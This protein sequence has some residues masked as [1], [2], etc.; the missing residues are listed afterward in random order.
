MSFLFAGI[1]RTAELSLFL[2][3]V[4]PGIASAASGP[5]AG[6]VTSSLTGFP[7]A[8]VVVKVLET[9]DSTQTDGTG[10][11]VFANLVNGRYTMLIGKPTYQPVTKANVFFGSC[12]QGTAG[13][14]DCD[15]TN[16]VDISDLSVLIDN[17]FISFS[18]L[19]C[20]A[21]AN[22]DGQPGVDI[23]DLSSLIDFL[24]ISFTTPAP[25]Q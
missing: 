4:V 11:Y 3:L 15:P 14:V 7:L 8:N 20:P 17:L 25:C 2:Y 9:S 6:K 1:R 22:V 5:V 24:F 16:N 10:H 23:S 19:C 21:A 13:N 12:C 18:P